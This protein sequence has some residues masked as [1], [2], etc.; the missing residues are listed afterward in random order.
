MKKEYFMF[1]TIIIIVVTGNFFTQ[2]NSKKVFSNMEDELSIL[3]E[4]IKTNESKEKIKQQM[5]HINEKWK[6]EYEVLAYYIE[7]DELEKIEVQYTLIKA[8]IDVESYEDSIIE[9]DKCVFLI[10]HVK[11]K[12]ALRLVNI[13]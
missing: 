2:R 8:S 12:E 10:D 3:E 5:E 7:H 9:I 4:M 11:D 13:F 1:F 6:K